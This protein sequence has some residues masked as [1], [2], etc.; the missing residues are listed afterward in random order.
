MEADIRSDGSFVL[1]PSPDFQF[2]LFV[3]AHRR[4]EWNVCVEWHGRWHVLE[5]QSLYTLSDSGPREIVEMKCQL[6]SSSRDTTCTSEEKFDF[7]DAEL[8]EVLGATR[9]KGVRP[10]A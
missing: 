5:T 6:G 2:F 4:F 7:T 1:C 10:D 3:M 8:R 9:C